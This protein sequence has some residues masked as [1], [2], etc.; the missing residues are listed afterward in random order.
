MD[1]RWHSRILDVPSFRAANCDTDHYL[2]VKKL[3]K[4]WQR[5]NKQRTYFKWRGSNSD[6]IVDIIRAW[7]TAF[8]FIQNFIQ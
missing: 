5:V 3:R 8:N 2:A 6:I 1:R 7:K 4:D